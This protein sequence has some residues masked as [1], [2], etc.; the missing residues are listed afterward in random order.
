MIGS[1]DVKGNEYGEQKWLVHTS[2]P[3]IIDSIV[4]LS[5]TN[6]PL[7]R[8]P[9]Y[10]SFFLPVFVRVDTQIDSNEHT[11]VYTYIHT[12]IH[13]MAFVENERCPIWKH[14]NTSR[15]QL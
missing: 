1:I 15:Q 6:M 3:Q 9:L 7:I 4:L 11:P 12:Y 13:T 5:A 10:P 8:P 2:L 14:A